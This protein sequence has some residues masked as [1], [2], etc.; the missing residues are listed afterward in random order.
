MFVIPVK[1]ASGLPPKFWLEKKQ[2]NF[3]RS[4]TLLLL[5]INKWYW[6]AHIDLIMGLKLPADYTDLV[7]QE[8]QVSG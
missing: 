1:V 8:I 3:Q 6:E 5:V 2:P 4:L 7:S